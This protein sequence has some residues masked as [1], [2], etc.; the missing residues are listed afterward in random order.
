MKRNMKCRVPGCRA[1]SKGPRFH[2]M[3]QKH[4]TLPEKKQLEY[5]INF[6]GNPT[7]HRAKKKGTNY[8]PVKVIETSTVKELDVATGKH[9]GKVVPK[10][11]LYES[12]INDVNQRILSLAAELKKLGAQV[13]FNF[14]IDVL[15]R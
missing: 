6:N 11:G 13:S 4:L 5:R 8:V 12:E 15:K 2:F 7:V 1:K 3:C 14:V 10:F 9:I